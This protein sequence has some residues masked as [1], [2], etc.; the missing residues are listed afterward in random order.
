MALKFTHSKLHPF[1]GL[2]KG[3]KNRRADR[4]KTANLVT[5]EL[6]KGI[7]LGTTFNGTTGKFTKVSR[8][9]S[10]L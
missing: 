10:I 3:G 4:R 9:P 7:T 8:T 2:L 1:A 5:Y 6:P